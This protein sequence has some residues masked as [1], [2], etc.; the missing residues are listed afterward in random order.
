MVKPCAVKC[1][2]NENHSNL[3]LSLH[4]GQVSITHPCSWKLT[5]RHVLFWRSV[6]LFSLFGT[7]LEFFLAVVVLGAGFADVFVW[8]AALGA[9]GPFLAQALATGL[10][11]PDPLAAPSACFGGWLATSFSFCSGSFSQAN[12]LSKS[13]Y[14]WTYWVS[15]SNFLRKSAFPPV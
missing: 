11:A 8:V 15:S 3:R 6:P 4:E 10:G 5:S 12:N 2:T 7:N 1:G 9:V 14:F 13:L